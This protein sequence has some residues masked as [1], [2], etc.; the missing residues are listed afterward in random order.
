MGSV[1]D[2]KKN[3]TTF[4]LCD[5][6]SEILVIEYDEELDIADLALY[7]NASSYCSKM[8]FWQRLRY[9]WQILWHKKPYADQM[10]LSRKQ[11]LELRSFLNSI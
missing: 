2:L 7:E 6:R 10:Q 3:K 1:T 8:S 5:C 9:I 4:L 11:I